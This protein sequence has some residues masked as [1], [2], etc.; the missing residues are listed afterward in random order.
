MEIDGVVHCFFEQ[1]GTFK[2]AFK[3]LGYTAYDYD[4]SN[5]FGETDYVIDLF[6]EIE[7]AYKHETSVF[8]NI[9]ENDL[10]LAFFP[11][12][13]F[14]EKSMWHFTYACKN[15]NHLDNVQKI[16]KIIERDKLRHKFYQTLLKFV[17]VCEGRRLRM[18]FE[19]PWMKP[20][21]LD[22]N[23]PIQP[24]LVDTDRSLRGDFRR[25]PT[26]YYFFNCEP[27]RGE[28]YASVEKNKILSHN[29]IRSSKTS[30]VC[31]IDRSV[32]SEEYALNFIND[33]I[34]GKESR[35][36]VGLFA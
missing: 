24:Q 32:M 5:E 20:H 30:G 34:L 27:T 9:T 19:N 15:Y 8:D 23:F 31:S 35:V 4:I 13:Y 28:S 18:I 11:C 36:N 12:I 25:K 16:E 29:N 21:Y 17:G 3:K 7:K 26:R 22:N 1:S 6:G 14:C 10:I 2:N 33:F